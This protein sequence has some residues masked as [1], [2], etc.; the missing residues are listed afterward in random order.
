M[1]MNSCSNADALMV[2]ISSSSH[3]STAQATITLS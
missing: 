2:M 1:A 3:G